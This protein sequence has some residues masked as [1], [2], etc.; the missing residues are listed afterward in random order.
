MSVI[1]VHTD[2][3]IDTAPAYLAQYYPDSRITFARDL[4]GEGYYTSLGGR[5]TYP[6]TV[7][8][9]RNGVIANV[10][11]SALTYDDLKQAVENLM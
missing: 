8:L 6:Y 1:A 9:D 10:F 5:G 2:M 4:A 3:I 11:V 7:I